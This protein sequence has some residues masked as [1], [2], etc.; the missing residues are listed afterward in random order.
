MKAIYIRTST[1]EQEPT[2]QLND[3]SK[4]IPI[5]DCTVFEE[6]ESAWKKNTKRPEFEKIVA[7]IKRKEITDLYAWDLDRLQRNRQG[8]KDLFLLCK[9]Y[10][11]NIHTF[12]QQWLEQLNSIAPPFDEIVKDLMIS[13]MGWLAEDESK[14]KSGRIKNAVRRTEKG[15]MSYKGNKWGRKEFPKQTISRVLKLHEQGISIRAI[16][17]EV[18]VYDKNNNSRNISKSS[19]HKILCQNV[20]EK[21]SISANPQ[22]T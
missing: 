4:L 2:L 16:A 3:I 14:K 6:Q 22:F 10:G 8:L 17:K 11:V 20:G 9:C 1:T 13:L 5:E 18:M 21:D 12:N 19:V 15:T 7:M